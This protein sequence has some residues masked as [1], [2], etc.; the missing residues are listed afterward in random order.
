MLL[1]HE[2]QHTKLYKVILLVF[3]HFVDTSDFLFACTDKILRL[4]VLRSRCLMLWTTT[5]DPSYQRSYDRDTRRTETMGGHF[6]VCQVQMQSYFIRSNRCDTFLQHVNV[7]RF[8]QLISIT[9]DN[10]TYICFIFMDGIDKTNDI[11]KLA[12]YIGHHRY[13][14]KSVSLI[15]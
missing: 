14:F 6:C 7:H 9:F 13:I 2:L 12:H 15:S 10:R 1:W 8:R 3:S 5:T 11:L 4:K